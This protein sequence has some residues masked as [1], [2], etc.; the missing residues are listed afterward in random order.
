MARQWYFIPSKPILDYIERV[1]GVFQFIGNPRDVWASDDK[2]LRSFHARN[3]KR[4]NNM[5]ERGHVGLYVADDF[6]ID[7]LKIHPAMIYGWDWFE[8][9][10]DEHPEGDEW[11][12]MVLPVNTP[13]AKPYARRR[14]PVQWRTLKAVA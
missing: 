14:Q 12:A 13:E 5:M 11:D 10:A 1:G 6:C 4:Y 9:Y 3:V 7:V 2:E 8:F